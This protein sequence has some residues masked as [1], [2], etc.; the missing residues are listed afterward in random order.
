MSEVTKNL[1]YTLYAESSIEHA[2][3]AVQLR[4]WIVEKGLDASTSQIE[5]EE[6]VDSDGRTHNY[7]TQ[8][9]LTVPCLVNIKKV[10]GSDA[11]ACDVIATGADAILNLSDSQIDAM[12]AA[13]AEY[14]KTPTNT[15]ITA[16][17]IG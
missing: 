14:T 15:R 2:D 10:E 11:L 1:L 12:K 16:R 8:F 13:Y 5:P 17:R 3:T 4:Q 7:I 9:G 6:F